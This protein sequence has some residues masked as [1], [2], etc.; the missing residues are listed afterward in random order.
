ML[1]DEATIEVQAGRGGDGAV[2]FRREAYVPKGGPDGGDGGDGGSVYL[3]ATRGVDTLLD[4]AGRHHWRADD[5]K[6]GRGKSRTG[7]KGKD[8]V[9]RVPPGTMVHDAADGMM[10]ADLAAV[11]DRLCAA[12]G[13]RGGFGNEHFKSATNQVPRRATPGQP[14]EQRS[15][16]LVLKLIADVGLIGKPNA[17][18]STLLAHISRAT[19]RIADYPFTTLEP[20][21]GIAEITGH[22]RIVLADIP[23]LIEGAHRG[24]G[25][26]L[27]FLRHIERTRLLVHVLEIDPLDGSDVVDNFHAINDELR[28]YSPTLAD[29]PQI[30]ALN[31][32][33]ALPE[34]DRQTAVELVQQ[35]IGRTVKPI[36]AV[37]GVGCEALLKTCWGR[38][39]WAKNQ[40]P[41]AEARREGPAAPQ[42]E[43]S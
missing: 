20:Q 26:G 8:L 27:T 5:G 13:G 35:A 16:D 18:K 6:A 25:L 17:G 24:A 9:I 4:M 7:G 42:R 2:S 10:L 31:K 29:K 41:V 28:R 21:L 37:S 12:K 30:V 32:M 11:G 34:G 15:L 3:E 43:T 36:S 33:D 39:E 19:P 22:R 1:I 14:G 23:G 38:L 40:Q